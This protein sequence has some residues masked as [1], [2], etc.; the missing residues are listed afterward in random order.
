MALATARWAETM[1]GAAAAVSASRG[2]GR[3][4]G[5]GRGGGSAEVV[6]LACSLVGLEKVGVGTLV[7]AMGAEVALA[8]AAEAMLEEVTDGKAAAAA[9]VAEVAKAT[10]AVAAEG[11]EDRSRCSRC[12]IRK[13]STLLQDHRRRNHH[14][15]HRSR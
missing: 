8:Q 15:K 6:G 7:V 12:P 3:A 14:Q 5:V 4:A 10:A 2:L 11:G 9:T 1:A 13:T